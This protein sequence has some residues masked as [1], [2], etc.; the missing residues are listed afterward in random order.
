M[1]NTV[2]GNFKQYELLGGMK[3]PDTKDYLALIRI[4][5]EEAANFQRRFAVEDTEA[6]KIVTIMETYL[7]RSGRV[8]YGGAAINAYLSASNKI[9]D[10]ALNLPDYD[11]LT[12]DPLQDTAD[13]IAEFQKEGFEEVEAKLGIHEGTYKIFVNFRP[14]A[15]IT[16]MPPSIYAD[17]QKSSRML[18]GIR[19]ASPDFLRMNIYLELS[20]PFGDQKRWEKIYGRLLLLNKEHPIQVRGRCTRSKRFQQKLFLLIK[21]I[22]IKRKAVFLSEWGLRKGVSSSSDIVLLVSDDTKPLCSDLESLGLRSKVFDALGEIMPRRTEFYKKTGHLVAVVFDTVACHAYQT[23]GEIRLG[24]V[25][26]LI[27]MYYSFYFV[28]LQKYISTPLLCTIQSLIDYEFKRIQ[29]ATKTK[30]QILPTTCIGHQPLLSEL[31]RAHR[32]RIKEKRK[33]IQQLTRK[34]RKKT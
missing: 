15:D 6:Q 29:R 13:L 31:K 23:Y 19:C 14:A 20:R 26:L 5:A 12:P 17:I 34:T 11:F 32:K 28:G 22:G 1:Q 30:E 16:Y 9:Y 18:D 4:A 8:V 2:S 25:E 27:T 24:S 3:H 33:D 21:S 10:P 7:K